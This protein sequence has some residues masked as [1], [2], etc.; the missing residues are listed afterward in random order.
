[1]GRGQAI[2]DVDGTLQELR[3]RK[4]S[5]FETIGQRLASQ[6]LHDDV[7]DVVLRADVIKRTDVG[8]TQR[9]DGARFTIETLFRFRILRDVGAEDLM[10]TLRS[11]RVSRAWYTSPMPPAPR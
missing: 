5:F 3:Q 11:R 2:A 1:M 8:V 10:A 4:R 9:R 7:A 6:V